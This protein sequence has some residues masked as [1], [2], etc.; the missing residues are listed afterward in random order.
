MVAVALANRFANDDDRLVTGVSSQRLVV[1]AIGFLAFRSGERLR[2][3]DLA[4]PGS[5][6]GLDRLGICRRKLI[7]ERESP[8]A[9]GAKASAFSSC[10]SSAINRHRRFSEASR[11]RFGCFTLSALARISAACKGGLAGGGEG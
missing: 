6:S 1:K 10:W 5:K 8:V 9:Q 2:F 7:F 11:G 3:L 4:Q